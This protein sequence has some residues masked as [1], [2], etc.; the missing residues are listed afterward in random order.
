MS[1]RCEFWGQGGYA[2]TTRETYRTEIR[3][4]QWEFWIVLG[5]KRLLDFHPETTH[6]SGQGLLTCYN[7]TSD[8]DML[9]GHLT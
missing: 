1:W 4:V 8:D 7:L 3:E 9:Q 2:A 6:L 5:R